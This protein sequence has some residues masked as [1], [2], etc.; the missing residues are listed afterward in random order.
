M[1]SMAHF[2]LFEKYKNSGAHA[3]STGVVTD[4]DKDLYQ[5]IFEA[6]EYST[7]QSIQGPQFNQWYKTWSTKFGRNG[8][9]QGHR[10]L[11]LWSS[12][13]NVESRSL[14][15]LSTSVCDCVRARI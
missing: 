7:E 11:D 4:A 1:L 6:L 14:W 5:Q 10:P 9:V 12:V 8:G 3:F 13:I 2:E 15:Q